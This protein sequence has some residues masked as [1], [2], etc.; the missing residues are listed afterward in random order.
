MPVTMPRTVMATVIVVME[1]GAKQCAA[2][3]TPTLMDQTRVTASAAPE[4][5]RQGLDQIRSTS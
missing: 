3:A 1:E 5:Q 2:R 4:R